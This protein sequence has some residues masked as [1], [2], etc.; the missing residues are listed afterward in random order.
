MQMEQTDSS[1]R[2]NKWWVFGAIGLGLFVSVMDQTGLTLAIPRIAEK[3]DA[4]IPTVQWVVLGYILV[5]SSLMLPMGRAADIIGRKRV[6]M[7]GFSIFTVGGVLAGVSPSLGAVIAMKM[8]QGI[9]TA[10]VQAT[11]MAIVTSTFPAEE[12]GKAIGMLTTVVGVGAMAGPVI[13]GFVVGSFGWR[14]IF[15]MAVPLG[16]L[17][18]LAASMVLAPD[19]GPSGGYGRGFR[20]FDFLGA[21]LSTLSLVGFLTIITFGQRIGWAS[22]V[23]VAGFLGT[24][25][26]LASFIVWE[27]RVDEPMMPMDLF[28]RLPFS[29]GVIAN[30]LSFLANTGMFFLMPFF[31]Q[32]VQGYTPGQAGLILVTTALCMALLGPFIGRLSDKY[33]TR[34]FTITGLSFSTVAFLLF[35]QLG[36]SSPLILIVVVLVLAGIG[37]ATFFS[38]NSSAI[39]GAVERERYGVATAF[40]NLVRNSANITGLAVATTL[41]TAA[42]ASRGFE[43]SL[44][45]VSEQ[46]GQAIKAA[47]T[48][49]LNRVFLLSAVYCG[50]ALVIS[51]L[52][53]KRDPAKAEDVRP[54]EAVEERV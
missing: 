6:Y 44:S 2:G 47:F 38:P 42:M 7:V 10:M 41:I 37:M 53:F 34:P 26:L 18:V 23:I 28:R 29:L 49:G 14:S 11:S 12:R 13:G 30:F 8:F 43:P 39:L 15:F 32:E 3:F 52:R 1:R 9:G 27:L 40:L 45:A 36:E 5:I 31:L 22:P 25:V 48:V 16:A 51:V 20:S 21:L 46:G 33:G 17:S 19:K 35:S 54:R 50:V 24:I 4:T